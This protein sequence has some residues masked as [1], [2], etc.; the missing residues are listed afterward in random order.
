MQREATHLT[1]VSKA[2]SPAGSAPGSRVTAPGTAGRAWGSHD[3]PFQI[4]ATAWRAGLWAWTLVWPTARQNVADGQETPSS[5]SWLLMACSCHLCPFHTSVNACWSVAPPTATH[6]L[7]L[8]HDTLVRLVAPGHGG[9]AERPPG[10]AVPQRAVRAAGHRL[11]C[12]H[13]SVGAAARDRAERSGCRGRSGGRG[14]DGRPHRASTSQQATAMPA[15]TA[16][17]PARVYLRGND[18]M[19]SSP[20]PLT[21]QCVY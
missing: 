7:W 8:A 19:S 1:P 12:P 14:R 18:S 11:A 3:E 9:S 5:R 21:R 6:L 20:L 13:A 15:A 4:I 2:P 16:T 10:R 17:E